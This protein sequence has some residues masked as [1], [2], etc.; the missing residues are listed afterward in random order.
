M[1]NGDSI[2]GFSGANEAIGTLILKFETEEAMLA[3][4]ENQ[5]EFIRVL[6]K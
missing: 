4:L 2:G 3:V 5:K 6:L 1:K